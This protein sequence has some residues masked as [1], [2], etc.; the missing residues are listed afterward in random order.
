ML[1][2]AI[3]KAIKSIMNK[4]VQTNKINFRTKIMKNVFSTARNYY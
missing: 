2:K 4:N 1:T 3:K